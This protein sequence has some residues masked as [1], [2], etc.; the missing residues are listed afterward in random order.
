MLL[1]AYGLSYD[2]HRPISETSLAVKSPPDQIAIPSL[3]LIGWR[4]GATPRI[5]FRDSR[6]GNV[7][8]I[9]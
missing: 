9:S 1:V 8:G 7:I 6:N 5:G 3:V 2:N 4:S